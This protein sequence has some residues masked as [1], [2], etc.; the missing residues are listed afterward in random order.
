[1]HREDRP[2]D[3]MECPHGEVRTC[4]NCSIKGSVENRHPSVG[5]DMFALDV[6]RRDML[7]RNAQA[8]RLEQYHARGKRLKCARK[9]LWKVSDEE[10]GLTT[11]YSLTAKPLPCPSP[12]VENSPMRQAMISDQPDLFKIICKIDVNVFEKL[13][14]HHPNWTFVDSVL[15]VLCKGFWPFADTMKEGYPKLWDGSWHLL[16]SE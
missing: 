9:Y 7:R 3:N 15:V 12:M 4:A 13:L 2:Q 16:K 6:E 1:M 5:T 14:T 8:K 11:G 10:L